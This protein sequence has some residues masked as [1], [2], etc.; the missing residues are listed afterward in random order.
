V[1]TAGQFCTVHS[2]K[3]CKCRDCDATIKN[4]SRFCETHS[5]LEN[6]KIEA[7]NIS[8]NDDAQEDSDSRLGCILAAAETFSS[9]ATDTFLLLRTVSDLPLQQPLVPIDIIDSKW[10]PQQS[11]YSSWDELLSVS[12]TIVQPSAKDVVNYSLTPSVADTAPSFDTFSA[13]VTSLCPDDD[14]LIQLSYF[15]DLF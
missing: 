12:T 13:K 7:K 8:P 14:D 10:S 11:E 5:E 15:T 1:A 9:T 6:R 4:G 3:L 2:R